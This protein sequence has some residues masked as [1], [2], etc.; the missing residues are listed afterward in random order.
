M[1]HFDLATLS[2]IWPHDEDLHGFPKSI[3]KI[4]L[5]FMSSGRFTFPQPK[6]IFTFA[7]HLVNLTHL[8][9]T[10]VMHPERLILPPNLYFL[11][12]SDPQKNAEVFDDSNR[13]YV[14][15][16]YVNNAKDN[17]KFLFLHHLN[18]LRYLH[19]AGFFRPEEVSFPSNIE[20]MYVHKC[21]P[22][23][24]ISFVA[25]LPNLAILSIYIDTSTI[26]QQHCFPKTLREIIVYDNNFSSSDVS[27]PSHIENVR[28]VKR[29][30][31]I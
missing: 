20:E 10:T 23:R 26:L 4:D 28:F 13:V 31:F 9:L 21:D 17:G 5:P 12:L 24:D 2:T 19:L 6:T 22:S 11:H 27:L 14:D 16:S 18:K 25:T 7:E 15:L 8:T 30:L 1:V 29:S 3:K